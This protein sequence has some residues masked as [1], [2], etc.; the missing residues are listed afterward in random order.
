VCASL[1]VTKEIRHVSSAGGVCYWGLLNDDTEADALKDCEERLS[2]FPAHWRWADPAT[3]LPKPTSGL[4]K[5][6]LQAGVTKGHVILRLRLRDH[7]LPAMT[8]GLGMD[9][10]NFVVLNWSPG[11]RVME[12]LAGFNNEEEAWAEIEPGRATRPVMSPMLAKACTVGSGRGV[13][14]AALGLTG[15]HD[16]QDLY[17]VTPEAMYT[18]A[19]RVRKAYDAREAAGRVPGP[20]L[21][22]QAGSDRVQNEEQANT[23]LGGHMA[24]GGR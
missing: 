1:V 18:G 9:C 6:S 23:C 2:D 24:A 12:A 8:E 13:V 4:D 19:V 5:R 14:V 22:P 10:L 3:E 21:G 17:R 16:A 15:L 7:P 11:G 20:T